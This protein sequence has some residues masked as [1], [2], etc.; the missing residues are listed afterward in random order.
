[1]K[2]DTSKLKNSKN[3][4]R[5][6]KKLVLNTFLHLWPVERLENRGVVQEFGICGSRFI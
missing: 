4:I 6:R 2:I 1:M 3:F 5:K